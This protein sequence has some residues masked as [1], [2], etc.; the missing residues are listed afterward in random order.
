MRVVMTQKLDKRTDVV[1]DQLANIVN[2]ENNT[3]VLQ[4][5]NSKTTFT[6]PVRTTSEHGLSR[7]HYALNPGYS[8]KICKTQGANIKKLIVA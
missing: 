4:F 5:P 6:Y 3:L 7:V 8:M 2:N 1:N